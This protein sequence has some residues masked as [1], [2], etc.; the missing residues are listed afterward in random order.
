MNSPVCGFLPGILESNSS[1]Q[2]DQENPFTDWNSSLFE[3]SLLL[4]LQEF[5]FTHL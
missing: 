5:Q 2:F 3:F 4:N 1:H